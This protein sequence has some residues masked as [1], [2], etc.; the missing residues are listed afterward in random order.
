MYVK[1]IKR[2][3]GVRGCTNDEENSDIHYIDFD[4]QNVSLF[5]DD[6]E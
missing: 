1:K 4:S 2:I 3:C 6:D 5:E